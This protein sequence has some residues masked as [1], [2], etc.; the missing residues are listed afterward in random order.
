[1]SVVLEDTRRIGR[2]IFDTEHETRSEV[3]SAA[4]PAHLTAVPA[5]SAVLL[6]STFSIRLGFGVFGSLTLQ[7]DDG[8]VL[9][10]THVTSAR[11]QVVLIGSPEEERL[12]DVQPAPDL[13][14]VE[15][16]ET[17]GLGLLDVGVVVINEIWI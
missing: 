10:A 15:L 8:S 11:A 9:G 12:V 17:H 13:V 3:P 16:S 2:Q 4:A 5:A 1:M 14:H 6:L 7:A